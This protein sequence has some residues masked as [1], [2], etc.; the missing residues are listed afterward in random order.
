M[1]SLVKFKWL[2]KEKE[3]WRRSQGEEPRKMPVVV[4]L[5]IVD[6]GMGAEG[7][8][9]DIN[10]SMGYDSEGIVSQEVDDTMSGGVSEDDSPA[11]RRRQGADIGRTRENPPLG[12]QHCAWGPG[13]VIYIRKAWP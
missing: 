13:Q 10:T 6:M 5:H 1:N 3:I 2:E 7:S 4:A 11:A 9:G 8:G 12:T